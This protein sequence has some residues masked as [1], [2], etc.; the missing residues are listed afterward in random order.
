M[1]RGC[2]SGWSVYKYVK[3]PY[4]LAWSATKPVAARIAKSDRYDRGVVVVI[5]SSG[6]RR[7]PACE[8]R[9]KRPRGQG[10]FVRP[11]Q[12]HLK[13][14]LDV[15]VG[16]ENLQVVELLAHADELDRQVELFLDAED[17]ASLGGAVELG[18]DDAS[19]VD[20]LL[21]HLGL[22]DGVLPA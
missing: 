7:R 16:V 15:I 1:C 5:M 11:L 19:A 21:E 18:Q 12:S 6:S 22:G 3:I 8:Y 10:K 17:R 9:Q 2:R 4:L 13:Q 14:F 20:R